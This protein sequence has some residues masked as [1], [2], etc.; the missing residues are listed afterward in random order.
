MRYIVMQI[1]FI[2]CM[3]IPAK[4]VAWGDLGHQIVCEITFSELNPNAKAKVKSLISRDSEYRSF[5]KSCTWPDHPRIRAREH[6]VNLERDQSEIT[7]DPCPTAKN[8]VVTAILKDMAELGL[9]NDP[10]EQLKLIKSLGH[11]VGDIHQPVHVSFADDKGAN[12]IRVGRPCNSSLHSVWDTCIIKESIG[13]DPNVVSAE[14]VTKITDTDRAKWTLNDVDQDAVVGWANESFEIA[15]Q[16]ETQYCVINGDT[17]QYSET[18]VVFT[19]VEKVVIA[20]QAYLDFHA[21]TVRQRLK[22]SG[23]R[24]AD[25]L[26]TIW[27]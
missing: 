21:P 10:D 4:A 11:W 23:V 6:Y 22:M 19:G 3:F 17:C 7:T 2:C 18:E 25:I 8:C 20:D 24:L 13:R 9:T 27:P 1:A 14:L 15:K 16:P 5:S 26:N 12:D